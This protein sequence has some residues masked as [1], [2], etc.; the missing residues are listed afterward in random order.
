VINIFCKFN[1]SHYTLTL[2]RLPAFYNFTEA[3]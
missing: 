1:W 3:R 2:I